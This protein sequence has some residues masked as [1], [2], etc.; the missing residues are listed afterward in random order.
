MQ[1]RQ[2]SFPAPKKFLIFELLARI[3]EHIL[4][5]HFEIRSDSPQLLPLPDR[6][7]QQRWR[8]ESII[9]EYVVQDGHLSVPTLKIFLILEPLSKIYGRILMWY[10]GIRFSIGF[11]FYILL[12]LCLFPFVCPYKRIRNSGSLAGRRRN[13]FYI[14]VLRF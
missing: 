6:R 13:L 3:Y 8:S 11:L 2:P 1:A 10:L 7:T 9:D 4:M 5:L 14:Y 12:L